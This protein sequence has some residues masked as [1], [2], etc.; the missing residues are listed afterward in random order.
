MKINK[1]E[2]ISKLD[3]I[4]SYEA[5]SV[6]ER[7]V[8]VLVSMAQGQ[9]TAYSIGN[10]FANGSMKPITIISVACSSVKPLLIR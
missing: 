3:K 5:V 4:M 6:A 2:T 10:S 1:K 7:S 9:S 8:G